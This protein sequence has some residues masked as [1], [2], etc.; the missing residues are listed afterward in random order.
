MEEG[1]RAGARSADPCRARR[2]ARQAHEH[3]EEPAPR[4]AARVAARQSPRRT[5][6]EIFWDSIVISRSAATSRHQIGRAHVFTPVTTAHIVCRLLLET[7]N[8]GNN[9]ENAMYS[10]QN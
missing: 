9:L 7:Q 1:Q 5:G 2:G 8:Y 4:P 3:G 10:T 6:P